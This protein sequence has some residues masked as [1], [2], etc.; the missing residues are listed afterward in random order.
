[1]KTDIYK[2]S[3]MLRKSRDMIWKHPV[4]LLLPL[5]LRI[6]ISSGVE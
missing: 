2:T 5:I 4:H 6:G 1:M 3:R